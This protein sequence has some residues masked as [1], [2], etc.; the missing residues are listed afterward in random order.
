VVPK[1]LTYAVQAGAGGYARGAV[2]SRLRDRRPRG[3]R[4]QRGRW[5]QCRP[6]VAEASPRRRPDEPVAESAIPRPVPREA[7]PK[8]AD[9]PAP[10]PNSPA[11]RPVA[12]P[13]RRVRPGTAPR[14]RSG[15]TPAACGGLGRCGADPACRCP[16]RCWRRLRSSRPTTT[17]GAVRTWTSTVY[18]R[19]G[20]RP[21]RPEDPSCLWSRSPPPAGTAG[22]GQA[23]DWVRC[24]VVKECARWAV[25]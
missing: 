13:A 10:G 4:I 15:K 23:D 22:S 3:C 19:T 17:I 14:R 7:N 24:P 12:V 21:T 18:C 25:F 2:R 1:R 20:R 9:P 5:R 11:A 16:S 8:P 6:Q